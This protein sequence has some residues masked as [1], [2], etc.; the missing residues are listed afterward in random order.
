[1]HAFAILEVLLGS[2]GPIELM[3]TLLLVKW[4]L[5]PRVADHPTRPIKHH[6]LGQVNELKIDIHSSHGLDLI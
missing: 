5:S 2:Y 1:M 3:I 4:S 6:S